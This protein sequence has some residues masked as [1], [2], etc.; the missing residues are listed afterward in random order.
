MSTAGVYVD[1]MKALVESLFADRN[2]T[3]ICNFGQ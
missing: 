3:I 1:Q 2:Y